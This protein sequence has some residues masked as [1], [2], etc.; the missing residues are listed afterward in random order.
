MLDYRNKTS[1][2]FYRIEDCNGKVIWKKIKEKA[3]P[4]TK[5]KI[6]VDDNFV[7]KYSGKIQSELVRSDH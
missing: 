4:S 3:W 2:I 6:V 7:N 5:R 1:E